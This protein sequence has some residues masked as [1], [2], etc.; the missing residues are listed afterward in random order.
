MDIDD[1]DL[2][3]GKSSHPPAYDPAPRGGQSSSSR[4]A[5]PMRDASPLPAPQPTKPATPML[6]RDS[7]EGETIFAVGDEGGFTDDEESDDEGRRLTGKKN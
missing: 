2:E 3:D 1:A 5:N 7:L 4:T 6:G